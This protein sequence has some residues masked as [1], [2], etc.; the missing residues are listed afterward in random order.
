VYF[1]LNDQKHLDVF[2]K[3]LYHI[4]KVL[5]TLP[6]YFDIILEFEFTGSKTSET[7]LR[8]NSLTT[9]SIDALIKDLTPA[10]IEKHL[11]DCI[12][13]TIDPDTNLEVDPK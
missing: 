11:K 13:K 2:A 8:A 1:E 6:R 10:F 3:S 5:G 7:I 9:K 4:S 12:L